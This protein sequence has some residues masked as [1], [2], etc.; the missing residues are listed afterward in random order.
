VKLHNYRLQQNTKL[1][2]NET[3]FNRL[4]SL[5]EKY[6]LPIQSEALCDDRVAFFRISVADILL[7]AGGALV[8]LLSDK[9]AS[10]FHFRT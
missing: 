10:S 4:S 1:I 2:L 8:S 6:F 9:P 5:I 7:A 3:G